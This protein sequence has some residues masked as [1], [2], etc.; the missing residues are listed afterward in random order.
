MTRGD[1][2]YNQARIADGNLTAFELL[3][4][5]CVGIT[6][7]QRARALV[8][9]GRIGPKTTAALP[10]RSWL[11]EPLDFV[12]AAAWLSRGGSYRFGA[13]RLIM[14][15]VTRWEDVALYPSERVWDCSELVQVAA[16]LCGVQS[17]DGSWNQARRSNAKQA[18]LVGGYQI[19]DLLFTFLDADG[20]RVEPG[21]ERPRR[22]HVAIYVG[23]G[24]LGPVVVH[25]S[26]AV[27]G[28]QETTSL[29]VTHV[30]R[31]W[32]GAQG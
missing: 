3:M 7:T 29:R 17:L 4:L 18:E 20:Q 27:V 26:P 28:L 15:K 23:P 19:G 12:W 1:L 31:L 11:A 13:E 8:P 30:G 14:P 24:I 2:A 22:A 21:N 9:D 25:A 32:D 6:Q 16:G 5:D 10:T